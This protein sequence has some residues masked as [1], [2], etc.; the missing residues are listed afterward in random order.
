MFAKK[1]CIEKMTY[2][3]ISCFK[4]WLEKYEL[5]FFFEI[6]VLFDFLFYFFSEQNEIVHYK[7]KTFLQS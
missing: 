5:F 7:N 3:I 1:S 2:H 6:I 4:C